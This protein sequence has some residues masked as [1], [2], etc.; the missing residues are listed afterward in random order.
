MN[1]REHLPQLE[2]PESIWETIEAKLGEDDLCDARPHRRLWPLVPAAAS[3]VLVVIGTVWWFGF[4]RSGWIETTA[5]AGT[6]LRI[7]DIGSVEVGPSTRVR[8]IDDRADRHRLDLAHGSIHAKIT[9]PPRLFLVGTKSGTVVDLGCEYSLQMDE[10]G[11]GDLHVSRGWV[12]FEWKGL[13]ALVPAG[14]MCRIRLLKGPDLPYFEDAS[15][16]FRQAVERGDIDFIIQSARPRDTLTLWHLLSRV[17]QV[18]RV[19]VYDRIAALTPIP[20]GIA[21][22]RVLALDPEA[23]DRLKEEL[24]WKW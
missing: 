13:E 23:L 4:H 9:A 1:I 24:A 14:A 5:T 12:S 16:S 19:R 3:A 11:S 21:Q 18:D 6:T 15:L 22:N 7:G 2:A 10:N 17:S 20:A 8:I